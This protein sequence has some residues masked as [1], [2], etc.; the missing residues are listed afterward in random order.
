MLK[1]SIEGNEQ[2]ECC[3]EQAECCV[4][5]I[6]VMMG[7]VTSQPSH[8]GGTLPRNSKSSPEER[9]CCQHTAHTG[10]YGVLPAWN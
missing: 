7:G 8:S 3:V 2:A 10:F 6:I 1:R 4:P 5:K 9:S